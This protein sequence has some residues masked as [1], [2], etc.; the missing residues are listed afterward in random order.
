MHSP[1]KPSLRPVVKGQLLL[2][3][4]VTASAGWSHGADVFRLALPQKP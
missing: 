3:V 2:G 1:R 4:L